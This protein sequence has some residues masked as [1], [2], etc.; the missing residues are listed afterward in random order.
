MTKLRDEKAYFY[1]LVGMANLLEPETELVMLETAKLA[2]AARGQEEIVGGI[3]GGADRDGGGMVEVSSE[4][5]S[6]IRH[7]ENEVNGRKKEIV[8]TLQFFVFSSSRNVLP[9]WNPQHS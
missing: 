9:I 3:G 7:L 5:R 4:L 1:N 6:K 8:L 2:K